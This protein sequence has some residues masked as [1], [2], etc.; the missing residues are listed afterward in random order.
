[1]R[2]INIKKWT[3]DLPIRSRL[4]YGYLLIFLVVI[5]VG[6]TVIYLFSRSVIN[7]DL[8]DELS[9]ST[10]ANRLMIEAAIK[11]SVIDQLRMVAEQNLEIVIGIYQDNLKEAEAKQ[12]ATRILLNQSIGKSGYLYV[13]NSQG[14]IVVHPQ[15]ELINTPLLPEQ[16]NQG[17]VNQKYGYL[18]FQSTASAARGWTSNM[19]HYRTYFG[20]WDWIITAAIQ[21]DDFSSHLNRDELRKSVLA[22]RF[23]ETGYSFVMDTV[24][25][26]LI[27]PKQEGQNIYTL[28][29][30][31]GYKFI[32]EICSLRQGKK[33]FTWQNPGE[34]EPR[35]A[36]IYFDHIPELDW[37]VLSAGFIEEFHRPLADLRLLITG[38]VLL[39]SGLIIA[40]TWQISNTITE[41][42]RHLSKGLRAVSQGD[43]S[44]RL[45]PTSKDEL[46]QLEHHF[47]SFLDQLEIS[48]RKLNESEK[49]F[50]SIFE[51]SVEGIFQF[52]MAGNILNVNPSFVAMLGYNS[53]QSL[54][55]EKVNF[56]RDLVVQKEVCNSIREEL[57]GE[58]TVKGIE[59]QLYRKSRAV[60]W[61]LLN[62]HSVH[63]TGSDEISHIEGFLSDIDDRKVAQ[64]GQEKVLEDMEVIVAKRTTELSDRIAELEQEKQLNR[65]MSEMADMM[66]SCRSTPETFPVIKQYLN[67]LFPDDTCKLY[68]HDETRKLIDQ[69]V[70]APQHP[71]LVS[72][73]TNDS[74]WALRQGKNYLFHEM[75]RDMSCEHAGNAPHGYICI[76][77]IASGITVGM[78]HI[79]FQE[80][81]HSNQENREIVLERKIRLSTRLAD[82]L[83][84]AFANLKLQEELKLKSIQDSLTGLANRRHMEEILQRQFHRLMRYE[85][86]CS[87]IMLDVDFFKRFNDTYGHEM[88][89]F[90]LQKL[91]SYLKEN[92]RGGDLACRY[93]GEEFIIIMIDTDTKQ[94][95][96][97]AE[98]IRSEVAD[99]LSLPHLSETLQIT[100]S[101]GV[102]TAPAHGSNMKELLKSVDTALYMAKNRGRNRVEVAEDQELSE[103]N[104][105][106]GP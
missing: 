29:D 101:C 43:F 97:K 25:N 38:I 105:E 49:G 56:Y 47:N 14:T 7:K 44:K 10:L 24:G 96:D 27:H 74:C 37:I 62:A 90:V 42:I 98:K 76:P 17:R 22:N 53:S 13:V 28:E 32:Q 86:P 34:Q 81:A 40:L 54:L 95:R 11:N 20:P 15:K 67:K 73:L 106:P 70:P 61:C 71:S 4:L 91:G 35:E 16:D 59:V 19:A 48:N 84:L 58:R 93:G 41:P 65:Y 69:V 8:T 26:L 3:R 78:L 30:V 57:I 5:L 52:D 68:L 83:S 33:Y 64:E 2:S 39:L 36:L 55:D 85:T 66:Q 89:D 9:S 60:F 103:V 31:D 94:A 79:V 88:G 72:S 92:T 46:G 80:M 87:L 82:H 75:D 18:D 51:N 6:N 1:M 102:A 104:T 21:R 77:L 99:T 50:R 100:V 12:R 63:T 45:S 23:G